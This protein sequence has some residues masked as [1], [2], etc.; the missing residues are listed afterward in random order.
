MTIGDKIRSMRTIKGYSQDNMAE[1]LGVSVTAYAKIERGET[2][3]NHSR[4]EQIAGVLKVSLPELVAF[5]EGQFIYIGTATASGNAITFSNGVVNNYG[6]DGKEIMERLT[7]IEERLLKLE[8]R[9]I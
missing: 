5:G 4:L 6:Q 8:T 9:E 2:D 1:L 3:I 7:S